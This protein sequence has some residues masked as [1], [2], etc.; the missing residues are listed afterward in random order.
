MN[1]KETLLKF[2]RSELAAL[3]GGRYGASEQQPWRARL[4]FEDCPCCP[5]FGDRERRVPC[6]D[7][8]LIDLVPKNRRSEEIPC[9]FIQLNAKGETID[10]LYRCGT[11]QELETAM[12]EWLHKTINEL[13]SQGAASRA[14]KAARH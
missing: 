12:A 4:V 10:S 2:L 13:K 7:C 3:E 5:N 14:V 9:R 11:A 8:A 1:D 6:K